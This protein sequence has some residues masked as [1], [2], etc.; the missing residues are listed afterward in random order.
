M[1]PAIEKW[2]HSVSLS[3]ARCLHW[4]WQG[5]FVIGLLVHS[6]KLW[7]MPNELILGNNV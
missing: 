1:F 4:E 6:R 3:K 5:S 7:Q 2:N